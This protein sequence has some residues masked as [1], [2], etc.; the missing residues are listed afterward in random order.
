[1]GRKKYIV[2]IL[3]TAL[4]LFL[5]LV[6]VAPLPRFNKPCSTV[7]LAGN[8]QLLGARI[9]ADGQWRFPTND[10]VP[11]KF[12]ICLIQFEDQYFQYHPGVNPVAIVR[13]LIQNI[14]AGRVVSGGST[15]SMQVARMAGNG[16]K[17]TITNKL[18]EI[19]SAL[20]LEIFNRKHSILSIYASNA[21]FGGNM[22]GIDAACWRYFGH[23]ASRLSWAEAATLAVLPNAPSL[24]Y[25]GTNDEK[26]KLKRNKL[27]K[28]LRDKKIIDPLDYELAIEETLPGKPFPLPDHSFHLTERLKKTNSGEL[29][30][31]GIDYQ[32]QQ[33][34]V[35]LVREHHN[36]LAAQ[37]VYNA[38]AMVIDVRNNQVRAYVG[39]SPANNPAE[40]NNQVDM[41]SSP[42]STGSILKPFLYA[43]MLSDG[44]MLPNALLPDIPV[45]LSGYAPRNFDYTFH[46]AVPASQALSWSLNIPSIYMLKR[47]GVDR[48]MDRLKQVGFT[49]FNK[50]SDHY[51]LSLILGGGETSL[52]ELCSA[53]AGLSRTLNNYH[54]HHQYYKENFDAP[55]LIPS[56]QTHQLTP[57]QSILE[58]DAIWFTFQALLQVNRP[59]D[60]SG[61]EYFQS[62]RQVAWKTGTSFGFR[63]AWA[64]ATTPDYV[65]GVWTG[66]SNGEGRPGLMGVT[67]AAPLL[68]HI[69]NLLPESAPHPQPDDQITYAEVCSHSGYRAGKNCHEV[70][71]TTIPE[72]GLKT[73]P[74]PYCQSVKITQTVTAANKNMNVPDEVKVERWFVLP[75]AMEFYFRKYNPAYLSLPVNTKSEKDNYQVME[76]IY[77]GANDKIYIPRSVDGNPGNVV[78]EVAHRE[79]SAKIFWHLDDQYIGATSYI[80]QKALSPALGQHL[81]TLTDEKGNSIKRLFTILNSAS[82][83]DR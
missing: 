11:E 8:G 12:K 22:V 79:N 61:W 2:R 16:K 27:L 74:C 51:G 17:R 58:A 69:L 19:L 35:E 26:L 44:E 57:Q 48:F 75:P 42:R 77:P 43:S 81:I 36:Q 80:H 28:R 67:A 38:S 23:S 63:D 14:K 37:H 31:T 24:I 62:S 59:E 55:S 7:V 34:V 39:N 1:M 30:Q 15:I 21:P 10:T 33:Q 68:F 9:A 13:S 49:S 47:Y 78:F 54:A 64:I 32:L 71:T 6:L 29:I 52:W 72:E 66:N 45:Y 5:I 4:G 76:F 60:Q 18:M 83:S 82:E 70:K 20:K 40:Y 46:G 3:A 53:Y 41:I 50:S 65:V 56:S 73:E 25:P